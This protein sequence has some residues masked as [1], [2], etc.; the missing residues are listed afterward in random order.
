MQNLELFAFTSNSDTTE[1][2]GYRIVQG[3]TRDNA[4]ARAIVMD[5][6]YARFCVMGCQSA[7][8][9]KYMVEP[10]LI[11]VYETVDEFFDNTKEAIQKRA[12]AKLNAEER[13]ALGYS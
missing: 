1:G 11:K 9:Y 6:R 4:L 5:K 13:A 2:R 10:A 8:D 3:Y 7:D 12:L